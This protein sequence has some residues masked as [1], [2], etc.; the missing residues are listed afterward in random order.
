[1]ASGGQ[2]SSLTSTILDSNETNIFL[3]V[4]PAVSLAKLS[5]N[6]LD[7]PRQSLRSFWL[8]C[9]KLIRESKT[10]LLID[11]NCM[12]KIFQEETSAKKEGDTT[13]TFESIVESAE[14]DHIETE[15]QLQ[16]I[17]DCILPP[18]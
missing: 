15:Q 8:S 17:L 13:V 11:C 1:M 10:D 3:Q 5:G 18:R 16:L 7:E 14:D 12:G 9:E 2:K 4:N 6:K